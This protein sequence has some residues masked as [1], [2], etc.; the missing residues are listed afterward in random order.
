MAYIPIIAKLIL[1]EEGQKLYNIYDDY[2]NSEQVESFGKKIADSYYTYIEHLLDCK[3][4]YYEKL[5]FLKTGLRDFSDN[6]DM[7]KE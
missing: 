7:Q 4:C 3:D 1:C 2:L 6:L 5:D